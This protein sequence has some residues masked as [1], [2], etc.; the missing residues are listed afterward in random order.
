MTGVTTLPAV[1]REL[2][3]AKAYAVL[4]T[5]NPDGAPQ[6]SIVWATYDGDDVI[7]STIL[8][9]RKTR[10]M[11]RDPRVS[12]C[13][14][15][16]ANG[17]RYVEVRGTVAM[18]EQGGPELIERLSWAYDGTAFTESDPANVRVVCRVTPTHTVVYD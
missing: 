12:L 4:C 3:D 14:F 18:T 7:F 10:N 5:L 16:P 11:S 9:R 13:V 6:S 2:L 8:G 1:V 17:D 15:E